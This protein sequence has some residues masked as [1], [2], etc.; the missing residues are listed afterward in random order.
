LAAS[1][2]SDQDRTGLL[3]LHYQRNTGHRFQ[4]L[5]FAEGGCVAVAQT[6]DGGGLA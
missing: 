3:L 4:A 2:N 6:F 5:Q 1:G